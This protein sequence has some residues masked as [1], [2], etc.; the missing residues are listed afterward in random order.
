MRP[1]CEENSAALNK[2][3][4]KYLETFAPALHAAFLK[5]DGWK[6]AGGIMQEHASG[7]ERFHFS[8]SRLEC[9]RETNGKN[10]LTKGKYRGV[11]AQ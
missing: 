11:R 4:L 8:T 5:V 10:G 2:M 1:Q 9:D 7:V 6:N 3:C